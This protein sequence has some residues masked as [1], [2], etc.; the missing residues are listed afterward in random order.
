MPFPLVED[1]LA[2][3]L[4]Q[5]GIASSSAN[6]GTEVGF[7]QRE[8]AVAELA[9]RCQSD[10]IAKRTKRVADRGDD[11]DASS[12]ILEIEV[13]GRRPLISHLGGSER[14]DFS[15]Q[16]REDLVSREYLA[17]FPVV[18]HVE[19]HVLD[20]SKLEVMFPGKL[21]QR[22][23]VLL[24]LPLEGDG[25]QLD[26]IET[27]GLCREDSLYDLIEAGSTRQDFES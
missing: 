25:V 8:E 4:G 15:R 20:E 13:G 5:V 17:P 21:S 19:R 3:G 10:P 11:A 22:N 14:S 16:P 23:D 1:T 27:G 12:A 9:V 2:D 26:G 24:R 7:L 6:E 18:G